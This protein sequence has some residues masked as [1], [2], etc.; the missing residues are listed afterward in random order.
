MCRTLITA[1]AANPWPLGER[2]LERLR[3]VEVGELCLFKRVIPQRTEFYFTG[4]VPRRLNDIDYHV[5]TA[6]RAMSLWRL[7][8]SGDVDLV[9]VFP[10]LRPAWDPGQAWTMLRHHG[11]KVIPILS[12]LMTMQLALAPRATAFR[13]CQRSASDSII[14]TGP[15]CQN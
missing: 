9:V 1:T 13:T 12:G 15:D 7:L 5:L 8:R 11:A 4:T 3:V 10:P 14:T 6:E 2:L